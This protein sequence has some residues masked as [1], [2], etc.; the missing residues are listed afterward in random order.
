MLIA[1]LAKPEGA[2]TFAALL[3]G[4]GPGFVIAFLLWKLTK[5]GDKLSGDLHKLREEWTK[6]Q[7]LQVQH[8]ESE[9]KL[10]RELA[11]E[12]AHWDAAREAKQAVNA[13]MMEMSGRLDSI[14]RRQDRMQEDAGRRVRS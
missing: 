7:R 10:L 5:I 11:E 2:D 12:R 6:N 14:E 4:G 9:E 8:F 13:A 3:D 1:E